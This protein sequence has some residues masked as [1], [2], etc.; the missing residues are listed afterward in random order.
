VR[1]SEAVAS[2]RSIRAFVDTPVDIGI[3][4]D[5]ID[6]AT[7]APS[8]GNL[9]P[10][11]LHIVSG[12]AMA[13]LKAIMRARL[14][15]VPR[16]EGAEYAVYPSPLDEPYRSRRFAV[17][18]AMYAPLGIGREDKLARLM[19]FANNYAFFGAPVGL[20][21]YVDRGH[22]SPQWSDCGMML[23]TLMLL[24]REAGLDSCA[25]EAWSVFPK[26]IGEFVGAPDTQMLFTGMAIGYRDPEAA[27][28]LFEVERAPLDAVATFHD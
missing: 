1:V 17:G 14:A 5:L 23:Q 28:N 12:E 7:R 19:W 8:G 2:R 22:G 16:G 21:C 6:R 15:E 18:E 27:V 9:Q 26:T 24:L 11:H 13:R 20:F 25:Q 3:L 4:R 10:W